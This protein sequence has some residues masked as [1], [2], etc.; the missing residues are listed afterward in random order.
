MVKEPP[1]SLADRPADTAAVP[2]LELSLLPAE[3]NIEP[4]SPLV[5]D[6]VDTSTVPVAAPSEILEEIET[7][8][9]SPAAPPL[10]VARDRAPLLVVKPWPD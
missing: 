6:P 4:A 1:D 3:K 2:P 9:L 10:L 5:A 8:P 7:E